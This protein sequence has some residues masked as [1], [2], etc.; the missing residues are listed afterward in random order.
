MT[1]RLALWS[2]G[3]GNIT[4]ML[5]AFKKYNAMYTMFHQFKSDFRGKVTAFEIEITPFFVGVARKVDRENL[6]SFSVVT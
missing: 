3:S 5:T 2:A 6:F 4:L 1:D